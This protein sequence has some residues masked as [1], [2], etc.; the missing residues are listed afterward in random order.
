MSMSQITLYS[1]TRTHIASKNKDGSEMFDPATLVLIGI[2]ASSLFLAF[3][4]YAYQ[5]KK[6]TKT[7]AA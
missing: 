7:E 4:E 2:G 6:R 1:P 3:I 5:R